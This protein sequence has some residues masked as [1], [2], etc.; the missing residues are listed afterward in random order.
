MYGRIVVTACLTAA[1][2]FLA[3]AAVMGDYARNHPPP[4]PETRPSL[5][6]VPVAGGAVRTVSAAVNDQ[7][8][9]A[10]SGFGARAPVLTQVGRA[11]TTATDTALRF[12]GGRGC[13]HPA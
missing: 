6:D 7:M 1:A 2:G 8:C 13:P 10:A 9:F 3:G 11:T 12:A 5:G 4:P